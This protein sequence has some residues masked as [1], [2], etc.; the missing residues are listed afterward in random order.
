M[1]PGILVLVAEDAPN[2]GILAAGAGSFEQ[3]FVTL[4]RGVHI[5]RGDDAAEQLA[6]RWAETADPEGATV[7]AGSWAQGKAELE[8]AGLKIG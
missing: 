6:A 1:S 2:R 7:P 5:G 8:K 4:T 3:A